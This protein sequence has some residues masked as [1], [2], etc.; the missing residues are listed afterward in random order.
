MTGTADP[1]ETLAPYLERFALTPDGS[2][3]ATPSSV[4]LPVH[5]DGHPAMLKVATEPEE[6]AG[7][8]LMVWWNGRGAARVYAHEG[9][10]IVL[11]R[12]LGGRSLTRMAHAGA[13]DDDAATRVLCGVAGRLHAVRGEPPAVT[14]GL[15]RWFAELRTHSQERGGFFARAASVAR[16]LLAEPR[17][18]RVLHGDLHHANVLDFGSDGWLAIDPKHLYGDRA[19]DFANILC[20]PDAELALAPGRLDRQVRVICDETGI[21][22]QRMLAWTVAWC[23]LSAAWSERAGQTT[24]HALAVGLA[25]ESLLA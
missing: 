13:A 9:P 10:A 25:A 8:Q 11:E 5:F 12:A 19:F 6:E 1:A 14:V 23:G 16:E 4:L 21:E 20:N 3:F 2:A 22:R 15:D 24:G 17:E 7:A 18:E